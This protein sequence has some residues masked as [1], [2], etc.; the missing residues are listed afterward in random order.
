VEQITQ[1]L[2]VIQCHSPYPGLHNKQ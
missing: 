1:L 2:S